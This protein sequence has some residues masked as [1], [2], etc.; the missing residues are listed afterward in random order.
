LFGFW[1]MNWIAFNAAQQVSL[2]DAFGGT[3]LPQSAGATLPFLVHPQAES[4]DGRFSS[5][6]RDRF[7]YK[8]SA[9]RVDG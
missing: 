3:P 1:E 8:V 6:D 4:A 7:S 2:R 9:R 5:L